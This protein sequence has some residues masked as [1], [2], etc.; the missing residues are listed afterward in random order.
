MRVSVI[1]PTLNEEENLKDVI[2]GIFDCAN[3][4]LMEVIVVDGGSSDNSISTAEKLGA[5]VLKS[6]IRS[7]AAQ[8]NLG[9]KSAQGEIFYFVHADTRILPGFIEDLQEVIINR[10]NHAGCY[11]YRF[12]SSD[13]LLKINSWF[14]RFN[15]LLSGGGDQTLFITQTVF[16]QLGGFDEYYTIMEDFDIVRRIR[17]NHKFCIIPKSILVSARKYETNSWFKVQIANLTVFLLFYL[18]RHPK[19]I[20]SIY[21]KI[22]VGR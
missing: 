5:I 6:S 19:K 17:K 13:I 16:R 14:T 9:A 7:R 21:H 22:L 18:K 15:G 3:Q 2:P 11:R 10:G 12:D 20:M 1:I 8:M 4:D